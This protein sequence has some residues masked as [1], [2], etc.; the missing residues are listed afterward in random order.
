MCLELFNLRRLLLHAF[1]AVAFAVSF[2]IH[3]REILISAL[4]RRGGGL[5]HSTLCPL[6]PW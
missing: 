3:G 1:V 4:G 5:S 6:A 2:N